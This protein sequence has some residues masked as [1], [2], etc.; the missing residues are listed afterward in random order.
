MGAI[1][2]ETGGAWAAFVAAWTSGT[3]FTASTLFYQ[4]ATYGEH[5]ASSA[6]WILGLLGFT[7][8]AIV[9]LR[10]WGQRDLESAAARPRE[11]QA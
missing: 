9:A 3:A 6:G 4:I 5:P 7:T 10:L 1:V 2:R 8:L 11:A